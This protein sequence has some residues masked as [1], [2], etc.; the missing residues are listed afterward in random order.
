MELAF[1]LVVRG[2]GVR[3]EAT[4]VGE[5]A[6]LL[7]RLDRGLKALAVNDL[8]RESQVQLSL[9]A[10]ES[11]STA[12]A[13]VTDNLPAISNAVNDLNAALAAQNVERL[14][15]PTQELVSTVRSWAERKSA[16]LALVPESKNYD[17]VPWISAGYPLPSQMAL[18]Y[19]ETVL[20]G[21]LLRV[22]GKN[23]KIGLLS[24]DA[25][26]LPCNASRELA[27]QAAAFLYCRVVLE[28]LASWDPD[29]WSLVSFTAH[30]L[31]DYSPGPIGE[32]LARLAELAGPDAWTDWDD[33]S[34]TIAALRKE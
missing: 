25:G 2:E 13:F 4:P 11:G 3:P 27:R 31:L 12:L 20:E 26:L 24:S 32:A 29:S 30:R 18:V 14:P 33:V 34:S 19:G 5:L 15:R 10:I 8:A 17:Q 23:P 6:D 9:V 28:G 1:R 7:V 16:S 22:G 21:L